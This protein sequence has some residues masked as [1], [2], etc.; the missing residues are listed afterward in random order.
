MRKER[1]LLVD[2]MQKVYDLFR[3]KYGERV[4][5]DFVTGVGDAIR[6]LRENR[7]DLVLTDYDLG[8]EG[9]T[10]LDVIKEAKER[11]M[12]A[13]MM[14]RGNHSDEALRAGA[15]AFIFKRRLLEGY[16][17]GNGRK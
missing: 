5:F 10:G 8:V 15:D 13:V 17:T 14:S 11:G 9:V 16:V 1:V 3:R 12:P 7:Y 6:K 2:D 4:N